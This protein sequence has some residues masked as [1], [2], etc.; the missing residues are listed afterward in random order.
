MHRL[1]HS[2][3][4]SMQVAG[5][6]TVQYNKSYHISKIHCNN[7]NPTLKTLLVIPPPTHSLPLAQ[8]P[9]ADQDRPILEVPKSH[10]MT[11]HSRQNISENYYWFLNNNTYIQ[12]YLQLNYTQDMFISTLIYETTYTNFTH[13]VYYIYIPMRGKKIPLR[14]CL[15][16]LRLYK[17]STTTDQQ[18]I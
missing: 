16:T 8:Q 4:T 14:L 7:P 18:I 3:H 17:L 11:H 5:Q 2:I 15:T 9:N 6:V 12:T 1:M 13:L 10:I